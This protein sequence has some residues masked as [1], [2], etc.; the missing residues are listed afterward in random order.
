[1]GEFDNYEEPIFNEE[2]KYYPPA[3]R[4]VSCDR[5]FLDDIIEKENEESLKT[6]DFS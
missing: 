3:Y 1:M 4:Q 2:E 6:L 5:V